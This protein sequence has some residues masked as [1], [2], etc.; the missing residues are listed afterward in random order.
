[1]AV[2][3]FLLAQTIIPDFQVNSE[4][5]PGSAPQVYPSI[6]CID[7]GGVIIWYDMRVPANGLRVFGTLIVRIHLSPFHLKVGLSL[8]GYNMVHIKYTGRFLIALVIL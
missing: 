6:S 2:T 5:Y 3:L 8:P 4:D 7:S 1:M